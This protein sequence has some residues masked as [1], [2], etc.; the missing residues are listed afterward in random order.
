MG[1]YIQSVDLDIQNGLLT[2]R[3]SFHPGLNILSGENG[4]FKT[5]TLQAIKANAT[6]TLFDP[7]SP[8][9]MQAVSPKRNA[10]RRA[11]QDIY[12]QFRRESKKL[13]AV[14]NERNINDA[15]FEDYPSLGDLYYVVFE[16][17]CK[18]GGNQREKMQEA[19]NDFN[20][21]ISKVFSHY[22]LVV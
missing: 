20:K 6:K 13:E 10:Q 7:Q 14:I 21:V 2:G 3:M 17:L 12:N 19:A 16:D 4:T 1:N 9:R 8:C 5:K 11:F 22:K 15:A 18:D